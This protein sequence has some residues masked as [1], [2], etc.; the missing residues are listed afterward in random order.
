MLSTTVAQTPSSVI[1]AHLNSL[2]AVLEAASPNNV[3]TT[4][5][6]TIFVYLF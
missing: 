6:A 5:T 3:A 4:H 2:Q 1:V